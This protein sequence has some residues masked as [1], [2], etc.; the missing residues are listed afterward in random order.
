VAAGGG[1]INVGHF[2]IERK[3]GGQWGREAIRWG[4]HG[5]RCAC[6]GGRRKAAGRPGWQR[7]T[8]L[9]WGGGSLLLDRRK[10]KV[11]WAFWAERLLGTDC[12]AGL[13]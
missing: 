5:G 12:A 3:G 6:H 13:S 10:E 1:S 7:V 4:K 2:G 9:D 8:V 11:D